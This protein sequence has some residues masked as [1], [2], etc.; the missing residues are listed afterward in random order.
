[1]PREMPRVAVLVDTSTGWGRR[2]IR[3]VLNFARKHGPWDI[4]LEPSG[5]AERL[6]LPEGWEGDGVIARIS[7]R[8]M[9]KH[10]VERGIKTVNVSA[11]RIP[12]FHFARVSS[13]ETKL[14]KMAIGHFLDRGIRQVGYVGLPHRSYS[15]DRKHSIEAACKEAELPFYNFVTRTERVT[16]KGWSLQ[17]DLLRRWISELPSPMGILTWDARLGLNVLRAARA[18][19]FQ[20]PEDFAV[21][22]AEEDEL[23]CETSLPTLSGVVVASEQ[24]GSE[25]A[26]LLSRALDGENISTCETRLSPP[27]VIERTSTEVLAID[28]PDLVAA[29]RFIR[30]NS[31]TAI[32]VED[33][34]KAVATSRRVLERRFKVGY[35]RTLGQEIARVHFERAK[36]LLATTN[37][38]ILAVAEASGY[39]SPEYLAAVFRRKA[40]CSPLKYRMDIQGR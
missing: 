15:N 40:G 27:C 3:G 32:S 13:D 14:A 24:I 29:I 31:G 22:S 9:A 20:V 1:M 35:N 37:M 16:G 2:L 7:N 21:L 8:Q 5:Q 19:G 25:A 11:I 17:H 30:S 10:L 6:R 36:M 4:L 18:E 23:L 34:A 28:D 33:V 12:D 38:P 39:G 26:S